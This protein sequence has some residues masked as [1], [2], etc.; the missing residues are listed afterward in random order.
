MMN[1]NVKKAYNELVEVSNGLRISEE[2][3]AAIEGYM[4]RLDDCLVHLMT[5]EQ[6]SHFASTLRTRIQDF[7]E[8]KVDKAYIVQYADKLAEL[9]EVTSASEDA[10]NSP[11]SNLREEA[12]A[13]C[14]NITSAV[15]AGYQVTKE[16]IK[17]EGPKYAAEAVST[18]KG[19]G[20]RLGGSIRKWLEED[21]EPTDDNTGEDQKTE[22]QQEEQ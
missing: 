3:A 18:I 7:N 22:N 1:E 20:K 8:G 10:G 19:V 15:Q 9:I 16:T 13:V 5:E 2:T 11:Y 17:S 12:K 4:R 21:D 6:Y 14:E